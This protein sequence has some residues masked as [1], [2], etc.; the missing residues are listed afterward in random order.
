MTLKDLI[1]KI[2]TENETK[3]LVDAYSVYDL[4]YTNARYKEA[5]NGKIRK[6]FIGDVSPTVRASINNL[7]VVVPYE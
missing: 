6:Q 4:S 2:E 1:K 5:M 3:H 7:S